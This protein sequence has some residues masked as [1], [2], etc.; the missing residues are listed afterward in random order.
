MKLKRE[1]IERREK[2]AFHYFTKNPGATGESFLTA[3]AAGTL[4]GQKEPK[5]N[6]GTVYAIRKEA[7]AALN[8]QA[9]TNSMTH[10]DAVS[11]PIQVQVPATH[12]QQIA[13]QPTASA[14]LPA[15]L[16]TAIQEVARLFRSDPNLGHISD[17]WIDRNEILIG[18]TTRIED[19][20]G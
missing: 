15:N 13:A 7:I 11:M 18:R 16:I 10:R 4:T 8:G 5:M 17:I 19:R 2:L 12:V 14:S 6:I 3:L 20:L 9:G 1:D